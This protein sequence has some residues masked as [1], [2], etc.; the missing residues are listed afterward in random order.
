MKPYDYNAHVSDARKPLTVGGFKDLGVAFVIGDVCKRDDGDPFKVNAIWVNGAVANGFRDEQKVV[1]FAWRPLNTLPDNPK[2][3]F[4]YND[5]DIRV[6]WRPLLEQAAKPDD[7]PV[8]TQA[9]A[10]AKS[11]FKSGQLV[12]IAQMNTLAGIVGKRYFVEQY[13]CG[14]LFQCE[15]VELGIIFDNK[16]DAEFKCKSMLGIDNR[17]PKQKAV[18]AAS[19]VIEMKHGSAGGAYKKYCETLYDAGLLKTDKEV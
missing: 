7:K 4:E 14:S 1:S 13:W 15:Y 9:M 18:D 19:L 11:K 3:K 2:F 5:G 12:Y 17:T 10:D 6:Q 8:F 16:D